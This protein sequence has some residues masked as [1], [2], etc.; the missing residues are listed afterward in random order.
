MSTRNW[1]DGDGRQRI[2]RWR[3]GLE[4]GSELAISRLVDRP[5]DRAENWVGWLELSNRQQMAAS[6]A[7]IFVISNQ[8]VSRSP[9]KTHLCPIHR[10]YKRLSKDTLESNW[11][12]TND[13][14]LYWSY[15][16]ENWIGKCWNLDS[17]A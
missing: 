4:A 5:N 15:W 16:L 3:R 14:L 13:I 1:E 8:A 12:P 6:R 9:L 10:Q 17:L 11:I 2:A 7:C